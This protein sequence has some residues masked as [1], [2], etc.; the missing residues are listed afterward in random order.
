MGR[1]EFP[2]L[3]LI[4]SEPRLDPVLFPLRAKWRSCRSARVSTLKKGLDTAGIV[5][6]ACF[7]QVVVSASGGFSKWWPYTTDEL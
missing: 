2:D 3:Q 5:R 1:T 6:D 4:E 7:Q